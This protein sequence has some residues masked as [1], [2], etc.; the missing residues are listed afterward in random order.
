MNLIADFGQAAELITF[1]QVL[2]LEVAV[3][4]IEYVVYALYAGW[5]LHLLGLTILANLATF[6]TGGAFLWKL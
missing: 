6:L 1:P 4:C 5:T 3:I 2:L